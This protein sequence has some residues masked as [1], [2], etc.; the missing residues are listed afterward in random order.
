MS[1]LTRRGFVKNSAAA[2]AGM[3]VIG[4]LLSG[5]ADAH[6]DGASGEHNEAVLAYVRDPRNGEIAVLTGGREVHVHDRRLAA[7]IAR[8][9]R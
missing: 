6:P 2:T 5:P 8:A 3:T 9:A 1:D 7:A 4:A